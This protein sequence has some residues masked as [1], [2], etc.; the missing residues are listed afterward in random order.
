MLQDKWISKAIGLLYLVLFQISGFLL[1][2]SL[3]QDKNTVDTSSFLPRDF[4]KAHDVKMLDDTLFIEVDNWD[5]FYPFG[6]LRRYQDIKK[7]QPQNTVI[8]KFIWYPYNGVPHKVFETDPVTHQLMERIDTTDTTDQVQAFRMS[9]KE[10]SI[11]YF[12]DDS[13]DNMGYIILNGRIVNDSI[14]L[15]SGVKVGMSKRKFLLKYFKNVT[16]EI[17]ENVNVVEIFFPEDGGSFSHFYN[18]QNG[19]LKAIY[20]RIE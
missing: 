20:F 10:S 9:Y 1:S 4:L 13:E 12:D 2:S 5:F 8:E 15:H 3:A 19:I 14:V 6:N 18:F 7:G 16:N 11:E 17:L